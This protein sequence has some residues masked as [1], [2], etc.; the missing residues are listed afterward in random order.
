MKKAAA[1]PVALI[2]TMASV[3]GLVAA[4]GSDATGVVPAESGGDRFWSTETDPHT[5]IG[6]RCL[7]TDDGIWCVLP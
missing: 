2:M 5:G 4:C 3:V 7:N 6:Y 1:A